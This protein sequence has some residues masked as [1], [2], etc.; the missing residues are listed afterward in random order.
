MSISCV[1]D[2]EM[3]IN[4]GLQSINIPKRLEHS[5]RY[6]VDGRYLFSSSST[7]LQ[8]SDIFHSKTRYFEFQ[9]SPKLLVNGHVC[10]FTSKPSVD[11][12]YP[13]NLDSVLMSFND[14]SYSGSSLYLGVGR[15]DL[16]KSVVFVEQAIYHNG[17][18]FNASWIPSSFPPDLKSGILYQGMF[19]Y[20]SCCGYIALQTDERGILRKTSV[21]EKPVR[22]EAFAVK[23]EFVYGLAERTE[24]MEVIGIDMMTLN[25]STGKIIRQPTSNWEELKDLYRWQIFTVVGKHFFTHLHSQSDN[26]SFL[27]SL[28][29]ESLE[30]K[31]RLTLNGRIDELISD[32]T[33]T[34]I[35]RVRTNPKDPSVVQYYRFVMDGPEK[36][37]TLAWL[38]LN[39]MFADC[40]SLYESVLRKLPATFNLKY[41]P[42]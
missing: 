35:V 21:I 10:T 36:L 12:L 25:L 28:D 39:K 17:Y 4:S 31:I 11:D 1:D 14:K 40:P 23:N 30:W 34:L 24:I 29:T 32:R 41:T 38:Q 42:L 20:P 37:S 18:T 16:E 22:T 7:R 27:V 26:T 6:T 33:R 8:I 2:A 9:F 5:C 3:S 13:L 19:N 15:V